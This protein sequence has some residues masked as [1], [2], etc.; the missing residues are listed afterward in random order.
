MRG[1]LLGLGLALSVLSAAP[2]GAQAPSGA[3]LDALTSSVAAELRCPVCQ[4]L[5]LADSP[6]E[7][8]MEM[9]AVIREQLAEGRSPEE[10]KAY[11]V[12]RYG[13]WILLEPP[14][15]GFNLLVYVLPL[16]AL[17]LGLVVVVLLV[18]RW[19]GEPRLSPD[20]P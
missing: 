11:F 20:Q 19:T 14:A 2:T 4:G 7:L 3:E 17:L 9:K 6:T 5:S 13:E 15:S 18:R 1:T 8:S 10:V 12:S 16:V